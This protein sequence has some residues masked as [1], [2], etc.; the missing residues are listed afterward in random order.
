MSDVALMG[1]I[2]LGYLAINVTRSRSHLINTCTWTLGHSFGKQNLVCEDFTDTSVLLC[3]LGC[4]S[5]KFN[6]SS[7]L[8]MDVLIPATI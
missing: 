7:K 6:D 1:L 8:C 5:N 4:M 3:T 2:S